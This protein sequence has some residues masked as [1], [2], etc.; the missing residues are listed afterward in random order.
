[1]T[2]I[3][4]LKKLLF[5]IDNFRQLGKTTV[6]VTGCFDLLHLAH[7]Q[8]LQN[9]KKAGDILI[10]GLETDQR[11]RQLKGK[12]RPINSWSVR[13]Q[14]L[15]QLPAV[16]MIFPLAKN[17]SQSAAQRKLI[18]KIKPDILAVSSHTFYLDKKQALLEKFGGKVKIVMEYDPRFS[19]SKVLLARKKA[20]KG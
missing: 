15:A 12:G 3:I 17:I 20:N 9:A 5:Y 19:T 18:Q 13:A 8:F 6:L 11:V 2:K 1:M 14:N 10:V 4:S 16:D 7:Q